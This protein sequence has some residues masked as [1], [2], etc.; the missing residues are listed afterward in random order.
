MNARYSTPVPHLDVTKNSA[1]AVVSV[2]ERN[3]REHRELGAVSGILCTEVLQQLRSAD[4][5]APYGS[6]SMMEQTHE[7]KDRI[8]E[9]W[10]RE[11]EMETGC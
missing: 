6:F 4:F 1:L 9:T 8:R 5:G 2:L 7:G 11:A 10:E 3:M